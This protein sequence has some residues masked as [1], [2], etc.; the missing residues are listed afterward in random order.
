MTE[1]QL[2]R[3][4]CTYLK[5]Q[6]PKARFHTDMSGVYLSGKWSLIADMKA[7]NSHAGY[8]DLWVHERSG[9]YIGLVMELKAEGKSP[10][11]KDGTMRKDDHLESQQL[12]IDHL[13]GL[14]YYARFV[15]GFEQAK[16]VIDNY[17]LNAKR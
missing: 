11:K 7:L 14:G 15:E 5:S 4:V 6:Y 13:R 16:N 2:H 9:Q 10:F 12:W 3:S 17:F 8:P 1:R